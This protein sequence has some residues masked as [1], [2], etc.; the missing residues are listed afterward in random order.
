MKSYRILIVD[1]DINMRTMLSTAIGRMAAGY[2]ILEADS[3]EKACDLL[4]EEEVDLILSDMKMAGMSGV[5]LLRKIRDDGST[6]P[7]IIVTAYGTI[8]NA[9]EAMRLGATDYLEKGETTM[10]KALEIK[11]IKCLQIK[12]IQDENKALRE[13][14]FKRYSYVGKNR[15]MDE[16]NKLVITVAQS[17]STVLITGESGTGKELIARGIHLNSKR[18][19][20]PFIKINC[21]A[22]PDTLI[23]SELF[24]HE[25]GSFTGALRK[26]R[27][28]FELADGGTILLDEIGEMPLMT[29]AKLL[30]VLQEK[31]INKIGAELPI[32]VDV[33]IVATTNRELKS[34]IAKGK[35][36][37]DLY[38]RLNVIPI[39][40]PPLRQ[41][42]DDIPLLVDHFIRTFNEENGLMVTGIADNALKA[43]KEYDWAGNVRELENAIERA[44]VLTRTGI[45]QPEVFTLTESLRTGG[46]NAIVPGTTIAEMEKQLIYKTLEYYKNNKTKVAEILGISI[47]TLRN[48]LNEYEG[49]AIEN[50]VE[51]SL[52]Q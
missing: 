48:K 42:K 28:K 26:T 12:E 45:L 49:V 9:V 5:E 10:L 11:V 4:K 40:L 14:Q 17:N 23:E 52:P 21:A 38:F 24:G 13:E 36:R 25:K 37:E 51:D 41:R 43:L 18:N 31:E 3:G 15:A 32:P 39:H 33:R 46:T 27:G 34:E 1:D 20:L 6:T 44:V 2:R 16:I 19:R 8:E 47:R 7:F 22:M 50:D 35:F 29:Q 30:R